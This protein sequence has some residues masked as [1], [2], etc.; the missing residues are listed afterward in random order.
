MRISSMF[1]LVSFAILLGTSAIADNYPSR[2]IKFVVPWPAGG[3]ADQRVRQIAEKLAKAVGQPVIVDN[4]PGA[5]G[6][7]GASTVAKAAPDGYTLLWGSIYDLAINPAIDSA[8]GYDPTRD[9]APITQAATSYLVLDARPGLGVKS[10]RDLISLAKAKPGELTCGTAGVATAAHFALER[11]NQNANIDITHVPYKGESPLLIDLLGGHVNI[12]FTV[13]TASLPYI[14]A[15]KV[16]PLAISSPKRLPPLA[17]VP[18]MAELG[19]PKLEMTL[20]GGVLAPAGTPEQILMLLH[21]ELGKILRSTE[22]REQWA[23][24]GA[25]AVA[26]TPEEFAALIKS[27]IARWASLIKQTGVKME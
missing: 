3:T 23:S 5:S 19:F 11:L 16:I 13:T 1:L 24:G 22:I 4:R 12:A 7:I 14:N 15:G 21:S 20:W 9:F 10:M 17:Q 25:Q 6:A 8:L 26:T 18:T 27:E 2:P